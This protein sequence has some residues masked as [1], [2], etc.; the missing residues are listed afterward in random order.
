MGA[1]RRVVVLR[2]VVD[3]AGS[4]DLDTVQIG[5]KSIVVFHPQHQVLDLRRIVDVERNP[6]KDR[7]P[8]GDGVGRL[9]LS[10]DQVAEAAGR[11]FEADRGLAGSPT[12]VVKA[13]RRPARSQRIVAGYKVTSLGELGN[14]RLNL[15]LIEIVDAVRQIQVLATHREV[16]LFD[17]LHRLRERSGSRHQDQRGLAHR[18]LSSAASDDMDAR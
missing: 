2:P 7:G 10:L 9:D 13:E 12:T 14:Q 6:H 17:D 8:I 16:I 4:S 1:G 3:R 5:H 11:V 15:A 18:S